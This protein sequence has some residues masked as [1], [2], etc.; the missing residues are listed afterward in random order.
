MICDRGYLSSDDSLH[1]SDPDTEL[2]SLQ[3]AHYRVRAE[4]INTMHSQDG[5]N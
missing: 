5:F 2:L 1:Y 3:A 4:V